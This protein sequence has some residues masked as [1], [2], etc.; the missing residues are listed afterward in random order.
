MIY[1]RWYVTTT[2]L[3]NLPNPWQDYFW[4]FATAQWQ[5][6]DVTAEN[7]DGLAA[8]AATDYL[9]EVKKNQANQANQGNDSNQK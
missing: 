5:K 9:E 8:A 6:Q 4:K 1:Y 2:N 3:Q 7:I